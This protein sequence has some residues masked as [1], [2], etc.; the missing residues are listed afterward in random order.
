MPQNEIALNHRISVRGVAEK[1]S[2]CLYQG[3]KCELNAIPLLQLN[4]KP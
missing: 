3:E 2:F 1:Y 4:S